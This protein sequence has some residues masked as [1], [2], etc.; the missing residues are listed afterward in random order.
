MKSDLLIKAEL[1]QNTLIAQATSDE[2]EKGDYVKL[3]KKFYL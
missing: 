1:L 2:I 3:R